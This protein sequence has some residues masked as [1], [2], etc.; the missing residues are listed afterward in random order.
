MTLLGDSVSPWN[1]LF[2]DC[3]NLHSQTGA[4]PNIS[5]CRFYFLPF[6]QPASK[7]SPNKIAYI[8]KAY[9]EI[10]YNSNQ[11]KKNW[12]WEACGQDGLSFLFQCFY[13]PSLG[14]ILNFVPETC[15]LNYSLS[16]WHSLTKRA[17]ENISFVP[18]YTA[19]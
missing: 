19:P 16:W 3:V 1:N 6:D 15:F 9:L 13:Y 12:F 17:F 5:F 7:L 8:Y 10:V 2:G 14:I 4:K 11:V 18:I